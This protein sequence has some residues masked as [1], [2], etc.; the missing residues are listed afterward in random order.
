[1]ALRITGR[2][3]LKFRLLSTVP[4]GSGLICVGYDPRV[5]VPNMFPDDNNA[6][7]SGKI[8]W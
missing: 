4:K 1:M 3:V 7:G 6:V 2:L 5:C 8:L